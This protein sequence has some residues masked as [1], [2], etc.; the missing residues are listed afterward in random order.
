MKA[1]CRL[2]DECP[3]DEQGCRHKGIHRVV[4][5]RVGGER[6]ACTTYLTSC[7]VGFR[8]VYCRVVREAK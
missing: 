7:V 6:K 5:K 8:A 2:A 3:M 4:K 1:R